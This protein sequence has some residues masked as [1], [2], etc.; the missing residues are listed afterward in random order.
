MRADAK[1]EFKMTFYT[2]PKIKALL[3]SSH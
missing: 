2:K 3:K 1:T